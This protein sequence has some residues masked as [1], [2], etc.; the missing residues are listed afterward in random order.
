VGELRI[1][2]SKLR[3]YAV[4]VSVIHRAIFLLPA[5]ATPLPLA[6][7]WIDVAIVEP[8]AEQ[9]IVGRTWVVAEVRSDEEIRRVEFFIDGRPAGTDSSPPYRVL[10]DLGDDGGEHEFRALA[11]GIDGSKDS[12]T[13]TTPGIH[14]DEKYQFNLQ[15]LY[16]TATLDDKP[17]HDL[18]EEDFIVIDE[19]ERQRLASFARGDI[20]FTA[21]VL[22]DASTSMRG[23]KHTSALRGAKSFANRMQPLD[24][25][26][27]IVFSDGIRT[28]SPFTSFS[29]VLT[30]SLER[31]PAAGGTAVNDVLYLA[32]NQLEERQGR[33]V[34]VLLSD[35]I[36]T[37][38]VMRMVHVVASARRS[39]AI[40]YFIRMRTGSPDQVFGDPPN[41]TSPWRN[42]QAHKAEFRLLQQVVEESG[43]KVFEIDTP[44]SIETAF[45]DVVSELRDHYVLGFYPN[46]PRDDGSWHKIRVKVKR[47]GVKVRTGAGYLDLE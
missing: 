34:V 26:K 44:A 39:R 38:S 5:I 15:Q 42:L 41:A 3:T 32:L 45:Q 28:T 47:P 36:D 6:A 8:S 17:V 24:E 21:V 19:D 1:K 18:R 43:G 14:I 40:V 31:V 7:A 4:G 37:H 27:L 20:P 10:V 25:T 46:D 12:A 35:G 2:N 9:A 33:R 13:V 29:D 22:V 16:V 30:A 23:E 11:V